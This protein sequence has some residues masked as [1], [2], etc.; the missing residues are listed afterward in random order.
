MYFGY[1]SSEEPTQSPGG[2]IEMLLISSGSKLGSDFQRWLPKGFLAP[3][4]INPGPCFPE[5]F[6]NNKAGGQ[7]TTQDLLSRFQAYREGGR[8]NI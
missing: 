8:L 6:L 2:G 4:N 7:P 1:S 5:N 3:S